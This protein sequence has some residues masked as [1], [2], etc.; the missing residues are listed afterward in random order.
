MKVRNCLLVGLMALGSIHVALAATAC[1]QFFV[2]GQPPTLPANLTARTTQVCY[3]DY[4]LEASGQTM[5]DLYSAEYLTAANVEANEAFSR[6][7]SWHQDHNIPD[8]DRGSS[9]DYTNS[10]YDRGHMAP[11]ADPG[12]PAAEKETFSMENVVPQTPTLNRGEW[13]KIEVHTRDMAKQYGSVYV[14]SGPMFASSNPKTIGTDHVIVPDYT[15]KAVYEPGVGAAAWV[16]SDD[17]AAICQVVSISQ[18][19]EWT[20]VDPFPALSQMIKST[21]ISLPIP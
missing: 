8:A 5:G 1:P 10:G 21:P 7:G 19:T 18:L 11:A 3:T 13:E 6:T 14:V 15:W 16:C 4:V 20:G 9:A 2:G 17:N 12:S